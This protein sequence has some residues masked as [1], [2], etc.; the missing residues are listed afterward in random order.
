MRKDRPHLRIISLKTQLIAIAFGEELLHID[1]RQE[2]L[3]L[4]GERLFGEEQLGIKTLDPNDP[5]YDGVY[6]N[7]KESHQKSAK[8]FNYHQGPEWI[9]PLGYYFMSC[10]RCHDFAPAGKQ[11]WMMGCLYNHRRAL[12]R[13]PQGAL[14]ELTNE[15]GKCMD[16]TCSLLFG[17]F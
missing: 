6:D 17:F 16:S 12:T 7:N 1:A 5:E 10:L 4:I 3:R 14:P 15:N 2:S 11:K 13:T 8:G 9:W